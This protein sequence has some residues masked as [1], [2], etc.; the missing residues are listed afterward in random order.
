MER[1]NNW[2]SSEKRGG[3][4]VRVGHGNIETLDAYRKM[5]LTSSWEWGEEERS[6]SGS[7]EIFFQNINFLSHKKN[8]SIY[9]IHVSLFVKKFKVWFTKLLHQSF[10]FYL[11][12]QRLIFWK[13]NTIFLRFHIPFILLLFKNQNSERIEQM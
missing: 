1:Q 12:A 5:S 7:V 8:Q 9:L 11:H 6:K 4:I 2:R 10:F 3:E 13:N